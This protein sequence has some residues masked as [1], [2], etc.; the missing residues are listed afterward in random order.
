MIVTIDVISVNFDD[1]RGGNI[2]AARRPAL[3]AADAVDQN[4]KIT[5]E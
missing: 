2:A 1:R 5:I 3:T 4:Y